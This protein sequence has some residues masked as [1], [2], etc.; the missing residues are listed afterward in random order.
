MERN[1]LTGTE[2]LNFGLQI[3]DLMHVA[4]QFLFNSNVNYAPFFF[5][6][7]RGSHIAFLYY[8]ITPTPVEV[9]PLISVDEE[10][11]NILMSLLR[12]ISY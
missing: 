3:R 4:I 11:E 6:H 9:L 7:A 8:E 1:I 10:Q 5:L 12:E 2:C